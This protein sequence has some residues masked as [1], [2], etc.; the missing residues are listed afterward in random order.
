V[1]DVAGDGAVAAQEKAVW[2]LASILFDEIDPSLTSSVRESDLDDILPRIRRDHLSS[3]WKKLVRAEAENELRQARSQE[4]KAFIWLTC[5]DVEEA[6]NA[7]VEGRNFH[8][9]T[10]VTQMPGEPRFQDTLSKQLEAWRN[11][12]SLSEF[13]DHLR[14][15]Y[16]LLAGNVCEASGRVGPGRENSI[17]N[18]EFS[19]RFNLDW[20]RA[21][22][23]RLWYGKNTTPIENAV[24]AF[25][26]EL[27]SGKEKVLPLPWFIQQKHDTIWTDPTPNEREDVLWGLL[28]L[29]ARVEPQDVDD[30]PNLATVLAPENVSGNPTDARL[31]FQLCQLLGSKNI[32]M[33]VYG[34]SD[35]APD[36]LAASD[37]LTITYAD[38]LARHISDQPEALRVAIWVLMHL[39]E[40]EAR[41][42][43]I[44]DLLDLNAHLLDPTREPIDLL[45]QSDVTKTWEFS[46]KALYARA[47][48]HDHVAEALWLIK[49][50]QWDEA[51][52]VATNIIG[53]TAIIEQDYDVLR[54]VLGE[55][56]HEFKRAGKEPFSSVDW[57]RGGGLFYDFIELCDL[58]SVH[59]ASRNRRGIT[60]LVTKLVDVLQGIAKQGLMDLEMRKRIAVQMMADKVAQ[61]EQSLAP[62][63][64]TKQAL[65]LPLTQDRL[66]SM[67]R[68]SAVEYFR[69]LI[70]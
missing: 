23:L 63:E 40:A 44:R 24:N 56:M 46:S 4:E 15:I 3:F 39:P 41:E 31:S 21:F 32:G 59:G 54:D 22:G 9:A 35:D 47:V 33:E 67:T 20:R 13:D 52:S 37:S 6:C 61:V 68:R 42:K 60:T 64:R 57:E 58:D 69:R 49:A 16:E 34:D 53:P 55:L 51:H 27:D 1:E 11:L 14:A 70:E 38:S 17:P 36:P 43:S 12:N 45:T 65:E 8:L 66:L 19:S 50:G 26:Q 5:G 2:E 28:K 48:E 25:F 29:Y 10:L 30:T 7:L 18:L 62:E